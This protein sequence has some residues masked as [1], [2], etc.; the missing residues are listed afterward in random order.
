MQNEDVGTLDVFN[1]SVGHICQFCEVF[2]V[3]LRVHLH[4][5]RIGFDECVIAAITGGQTLVF[6]VDAA[7]VFQDF[8]Q[9]SVDLREIV[10]VNVLQLDEDFL[11]RS[12]KLTIFS[13]PV[14]CSVGFLSEYP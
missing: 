1:G 14:F 6:L 2:S 11:S 5:I 3:E 10:E 7:K 4:H 12:S 13:A 8:Q 9:L